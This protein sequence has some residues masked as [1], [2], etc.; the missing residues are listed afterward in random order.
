MK[1]P[2]KFLWLV[3]SLIYCSL[4]V[5]IFWIV[6]YYAKM[7]MIVWF[8]GLFFQSAFFHRYS[9]HQ[10]YTMSLFMEKIFFLGAYLFQGSSYLSAYTY[11]LMHRIHHA[12]TDT[13][14]DPHSPKYDETAISM[15]LRTARTYNMMF[16][17]ERYM[18]NHIP[19]KF[20]KNLPSWHSVDML[21]HNWI[22]RVAW[23]VLYT[24]LFVWFAHTVDHVNG[25][26]WIIWTVL[27]IIMF[28]M[29]PFH[30]LIVNWYG[31]VYG[32][33]NHHTGDLSRN[34]GTRFIAVF[35]NFIM[36][37]EDLHNNHHHAMHAA[38]FTCR[39]W[40][41]DMIY[42][43]LY[44]LHSLGIITLKRVSR[45][46]IVHNSTPTQHIYAVT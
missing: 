15:M 23:I 29:G 24:A 3:K 9:A 22:S 37:G 26:E 44:L 14:L 43:C 2:Q 41:Y 28:G 45:N 20:K 33:R 46:P 25:F 39:W 7:F 38:N 42:S 13:H 6:P 1:T 10:T 4:W 18:G 11:G 21:G 36:M 5:A 35:M 19:S 8:G 34:I 17:H 31:H 16:H 30:G 27:L 32:Y 12:H 40:E